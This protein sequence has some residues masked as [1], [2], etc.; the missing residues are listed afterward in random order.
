MLVWT[1]DH[2]ASTAGAS[3]S[4]KVTRVVPDDEAVDLVGLDSFVPESV[5]NGVDLIP[6]V[7]DLREVS[8]V[9]GVVES[10]RIESERRRVASLSTSAS[11]PMRDGDVDPDPARRVDVTLSCRPGEGDGPV[12]SE[13]SCL[14]RPI[15]AH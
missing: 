12:P 3:S 15:M 4:R 5:Q 9:D 1:L 11:V 8:F 13:C 14:H 10:D 2:S 7:V 6:E